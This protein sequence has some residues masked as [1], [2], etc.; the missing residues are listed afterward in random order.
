MHTFHAWLSGAAHASPALAVAARFDARDLLIDELDLA[1]DCQE[2]V[3]SVG[4]LDQPRLSLNW[5]APNGRQWSLHPAS[6]SD[7][8][9]LL[10]TAPSALQA[11]FGPWHRRSSAARLASARIW[12]AIIALPA[13][14]ALLLL[15]LWLAYPHASAWLAT[16]I[17]VALEERLGDALLA[18]LREDGNLVESGA[19]QQAVQ[20]TGQRLSAESR[21]HY[22]WVIKQDASLNAFALPGAIVVVHLGLLQKMSSASELAGVLAHEVQHVEQRHGLKQM[23]SSLGLAGILA[24]TVGDVSAMAALIAHQA[25]ST[26]FGRDLEAQADRLGVQALLRAQ[27]RPDGMVSLFHK[28]EQ[29]QPSKEAEE[30]KNAPAWMMS[31]PQTAQ[32][33]SDVEALIAQQPCPACSDLADDSRAL[34]QALATQEK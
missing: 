30:A 14:G 22:R 9:A 34:A 33:I 27:I 19:L 31:H 26:Y 29:R 25:G 5:L 4:G 7:L 6:A 15:S 21:Y 32:R 13:L 23:V 18:S 12:G 16:Q 2:I 20:Q 17:P 1:Q 3:V 24:L 8:A 10:A 11:Q 28:L